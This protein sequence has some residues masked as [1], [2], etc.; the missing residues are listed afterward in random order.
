MVTLFAN[1]FK[2]P[3][4]EH[5]MGSSA[6]HFYDVVRIAER[7]EQ[8][9]R[10][11]RIAEPIE[12]RCFIGKKKENEM[13]NLE[14]EYKGRS[15]NY[16]TPTTQVTSINFAKPSIPNQPNQTKFPANNQINYQ[17]R[18]NRLSEEQLPPLPI[19]LK[20][21]Y[22]KLLSIGQIAPLTVPLMQP[23]FP[24][25]YNPE[26]TCEYH[27]GHASHNIE[28]CFAFKSK[29]LQLIKVGWVTLEDLPNVNSN[30]LPKHVASSAGV[31]TM[32]IDSKERVLKVTMTKLY[33]MLVQFGHL[34]KS[35]ECCKKTLKELRIEAINDNEEIK[36]IENK[37]K[38]R[39]QST[40][41]GLS[42]LV[43]T[44]PLM[45]NKAN[46]EAMP[47][48]YGY[49]SNIESPLPLFQAEISGITRSGR[50]FTPEEL[51][52]QRKAKGK[53]VLDLDKEF[54]VNKLVIGEETNKFLKLMKHS[55][56]NIVDQLKKTPAKISIMSLIL[57][58]E[59]HRNALQKVLN[60]TY[61][62]Q[63]IKQ[64][65][66]EHLVGRIHAANYLYFTEDELDAEG[67]RHNKPLYVTVR[68]KDCLIGKVLIDNGS[69]LNVFP[70]HM[71]DEMPVDPSHM[72]PSVMM[73]RAYDGSP[74]QV[75]GT[76]KVG[77]I[78]GPQVFL[79]TLQVMDNHPSYS[80]LL[81]RLWI[82]SAGAFTPSLRQCLKYIANGV[83]VIV[84][85]EETI[86]MVRNVAVPFIEAKDYK[87]GNLYAFEVVNTEWMPENTVVR[88]PE[89]SEATK[90]AANN[91]LKHKIPFPYDIE[92]GRLEW[93]DII[94]L[95]VAEQRF[96]L[97]YKSKRRI[98]SELLVQ[99]QR[100]EWLG[101]KEGSLKKKA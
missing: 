100:R 53:E 68:C 45:A 76:I 19:T 32:E 44:K 3:Y 8:E 55:E 37:E 58:S 61:I 73:A 80:M 64:K 57:S 81:G 35:T 70:K 69:T 49:T 40:A 5:L 17:R 34:E 98:T 56:Y 96:G 9:K 18:D 67:T 29:V 72:Q 26:V 65:T 95:K 91:F 23:P 11:G 38:C 1:T 78:M 59:P 20:E 36:M 42:K 7:I 94:K 31:N 6:Q 97:G 2:A 50:Y 82:H 30:P 77:L 4:Y 83:L 24:T 85:A 33:F 52:K 84:K 74:R 92:K 63:D 15:K 13:N 90:M 43:L 41:N 62:P 101:L 89:I 48:D 51:E 71:L 27:A 46:Y 22:A 87:D 10:S 66:V 16:Q 14:G 39:I 75:I 60:E 88:K 28:A 47:G 12:K 54:E 93:M 25:W 86:S 79:V 99:E 21:L